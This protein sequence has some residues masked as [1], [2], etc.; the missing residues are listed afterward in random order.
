MKILGE[1]SMQNSV[2]TRLYFLY[3][4]HTRQPGSEAKA[5]S[6]TEYVWIRRGSPLLITNTRDKSWKEGKGRH[7]VGQ[8]SLVARIPSEQHLQVA[9]SCRQF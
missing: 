7:K 4:T 9:F 8:F 5:E 1:L 6:F 3:S 2:C